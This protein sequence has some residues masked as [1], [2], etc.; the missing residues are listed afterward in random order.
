[1]DNKVNL[2]TFTTTALYGKS[3]DFFIGRE[4]MLNEMGGLILDM[5]NIG[6]SGGPGTGKSTMLNM[7]EKR[8]NSIKYFKKGSKIIR[9]SYNRPNLSDFLKKL[10]FILLDNL[11]EEEVDKIDLNKIREEYNYT[12]GLREFLR[13]LIRYEP[14]K[15]LDGFQ[16]L[17]LYNDFLLNELKSN[18]Q[19]VV[20]KYLTPE[21]I[22]STIIRIFKNIKK[23]LVIFIDDMDKVR[24]DP[25]TKNTSE[26]RLASFFYEIREFFELSKITWIITLPVNFFEKYRIQFNRPD[27]MSFLSMFTD[28]FLL[29]NFNRRRTIEMFRKRLDDSNF[30]GKIIDFIDS[31]A[32]NLLLDL[33]RGNP[34]LF[35]Y[36]LMKAFKLKEAQLSGSK[37]K[38]RVQKY[39]EDVKHE[40]ESEESTEEEEENNTKTDTRIK[41]NHIL[42]SID[43]IFDLDK[44]NRKIIAYIAY[45]QKTQANDHE[46]QERTN[47]DRLALNRRLKQLVK[48]GFLEYF[49]DDYGKRLYTT[50]KLK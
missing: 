24:F 25:L 50:K 32:L 29:N 10:L 39:L 34:R 48:Q 15:E 19:G 46:L 13:S 45:K 42:S 16:V 43:Y 44:K 41:V 18:D 4:Q 37:E 1:M 23:N 12:T 35:L 30:E 28:I 26:D 22:M 11:N 17:R 6:I 36:F 49:L 47:L 5:Q 8:L 20:I 9:F 7:L 33:S 31:F 14:T 40:N 27:S 21:Q 38:S 2:K 3:L